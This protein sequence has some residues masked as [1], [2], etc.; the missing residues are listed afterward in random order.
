[1]NLRFLTFLVT[2]FAIFAP[3]SASAQLPEVKSPRADRENQFIR[4]LRGWP[5]G[6][7]SLDDF[8]PELL[9]P[10]GKED[11][12]LPGGYYQL[13]TV[14][15]SSYYFED[16][17]GVHAIYDSDYPIESMANLFVLTLEEGTDVGMDITFRTHDYGSTQQLST[18]VNKFI[19]LC[20]AEGCKVFFGIEKLTDDEMA[21]ALFLC[22]FQEGYNHV[23]KIEC[24]P[25]EVIDNNAPV[26]ATLSLFVP[27]DNVDNYYAQ[28]AN[29]KSRAMQNYQKRK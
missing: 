23:A 6:V 9:E 22:N 8:N 4:T 11:Y 29:R 19:T 28:P 18:S 20:Q 16:L 15:G 26:R 17:L 5:G 12:E 7:D 10:Y 14:K 27:A 2:I 21:A 24:N 3:F 25:R 1:M 13:K